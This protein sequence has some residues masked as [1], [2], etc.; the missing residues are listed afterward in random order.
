MPVTPLT[1]AG[2]PATFAWSG[3][4]PADG[5]RWGYIRWQPVAG[6][7]A[8]VFDSFADDPGTNGETDKAQLLDA[9][10]AVRFDRVYRCAVNF[11]LTWMP[12][13]ATVTSCVFNGG[14]RPSA[15]V[16][17]S[18]G[19]ASFLVSVTSGPGLNVKPVRP[20]SD[21]SGTPM[22]Y[23]DAGR[24]RLLAGDRMVTVEQLDVQLARSDAL[25]L[26]AAVEPITTTD[27]AGWP[28]DPLR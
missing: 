15:T 1:V 27:P 11:R 13:N 26:A 12:P 14:E 20:N 28:S 22:E 19:A 5:A 17:L 4:Y 25:H 6:T 24:V 21:Y 8:Q 10:A 23:S 2:R 9:V 3:M 18:S 7:W 16:H